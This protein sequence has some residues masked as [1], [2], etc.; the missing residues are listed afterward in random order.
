MPY[1][2]Q[3]GLLN[4]PPQKR[5]RALRASRKARRRTSNAR[6]LPCYSVMI[7]NF[8]QIFYDEDKKNFDYTFKM[9]IPSNYVTKLIGQS[10]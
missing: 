6:Y 5:L 10:T 3:V 4:P 2:V 9:L 1:Q 8:I 7:L